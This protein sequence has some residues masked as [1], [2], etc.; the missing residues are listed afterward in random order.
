MARGQRR[1]AA[2]GAAPAMSQGRAAACLAESRELRAA[3][4]DE[5]PPRGPATG[6]RKS[7]AGLVVTTP[8][9]AGRGA[10]GSE[11]SLE[12]NKKKFAFLVY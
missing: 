3:A 2:G 9:S 6:A 11:A 12:V 5:R 1:R 8:C 4:A 7:R 10:G